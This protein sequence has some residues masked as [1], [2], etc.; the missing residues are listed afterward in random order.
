M[1]VFYVDGSGWNGKESKWCVIIR[2]NGDKYSLQNKI[3]RC[4]EE[5][6][7]NEVEYY[8]L[9]EA[10]K[11]AI[12]GDIIYSDS[13]LVVNQFNDKWKI[14]YSHLRKLKDIAKRLIRNKFVKV[15]WI[16]REKNF[17]GR[18]LEHE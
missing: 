8:A 4:N 2:I 13:Q 16:P 17:A 12:S 1:T 3:F 6:T 11:I 7:N 5:L 18:I 9:I 10:L 15:C 14:N